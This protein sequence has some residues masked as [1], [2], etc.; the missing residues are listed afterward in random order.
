MSKHIKETVAAYDQ[1]SAEY[2]ESGRDRSALKPHLDRFSSLFSPA[3]LVLDIGAGPGFDSAELIARGLDAWSVDLSLGMLAAGLGEYHVTRV[4]ADMRHLPFMSKSVP[5]VW[6]CAS[7]LHLS[8]ADAMIALEEFH[9]LLRPG[10][11]I[12]LSVKSGDSSGWSPC[13][14]GQR[15]YAYWSAHEID[16]ALKSSGFVIRY[17]DETTHAENVWLSRIATAKGQL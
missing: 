8:R 5:G 13:V 14:S 15:W 12:Y 6:A 4:Q 7:L 3:D 16:L 10:G 9:R 1:S 11:S 17:R 2:L